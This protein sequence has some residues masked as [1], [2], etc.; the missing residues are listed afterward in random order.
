MLLTI[1]SLSL[2]SYL[3]WLSKIVQNL[4]NEDAE[5]SGRNYDKNIVTH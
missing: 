4:Q 1:F 3:F 5:N 2:N